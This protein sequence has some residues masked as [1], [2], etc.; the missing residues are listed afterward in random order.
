MKI[1]LFALKNIIANCLDEQGVSNYIFEILSG[2]W[3]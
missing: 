1:F 2:K 3:F